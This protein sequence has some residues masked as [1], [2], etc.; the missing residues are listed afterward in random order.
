MD[1]KTFIS[2]DFFSYFLLIQSSS[3]ASKYPFYAAKN[4]TAFP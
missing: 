2:Y 4:Q 3:K 1:N